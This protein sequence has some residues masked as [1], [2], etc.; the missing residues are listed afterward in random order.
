M[1]GSV[2]GI[3]GLAGALGGMLMAKYA[4]IILESVGSFQPIFILASCAYLVA[5]LVLH[6]I[7]PR[8]A[9]VTLSEE[10]A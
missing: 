9:P 10:T 3:G 2:I 8:Y 1:A 7:V 5:L 4:G 6:L